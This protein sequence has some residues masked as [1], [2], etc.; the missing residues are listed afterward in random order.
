LRPEA[1]TAAAWSRTVFP[2]ALPTRF[3]FRLNQ[4]TLVS[5]P[6]TRKGLCRRLTEETLHLVHAFSRPTCDQMDNAS[7]KS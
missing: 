2:Y 6:S 4:D 5:L 1:A 7:R 3:Q